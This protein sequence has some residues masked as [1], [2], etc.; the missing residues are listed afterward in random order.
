MSLSATTNAGVTKL[1]T[2]RLE[3]FG[4]VQVP[5]HGV[6]M[7]PFIKEGDNCLFKVVEPYGISEGDVILYRTVKE[8][9]V[10]HR[11]IQIIHDEHNTRYICKG[12]TNCYPDA[13]VRSDR[14]LGKL[15]TIYRRG[16]AIHLDG[17]TRRLWTWAVLRIPLLLR[18]SRWAVIR[19]D[20]WR[21]RLEKLRK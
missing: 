5:S 19:L 16:K 14:V 20:I 17:R 6:S 1:L 4:C 10:G 21:H 13:P 12:D 15:V 2:R 8:N 3:Q 11:V 7:Y 9:L 18:M